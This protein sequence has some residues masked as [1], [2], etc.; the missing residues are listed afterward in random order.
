MNEPIID[1]AT[2]WPAWPTYGLTQDLLPTIEN[3]AGQGRRVAVATLVNIVGTSP[4]PLGSEMAISDRGEVAGY[5]SG[6][7]VEGAVAAE[8][9]A[10]MADGKPRLL[11]YGAGS[12]VLDVQLTCGG[13]IGIFVRVLEDATSYAA[14]LRSARDNRQLLE[15]HIN[16]DNGKH[17]YVLPEAQAP[18]A[19]P[20]ANAVFIKSF[21]PAPRL[22]AIGKNP[23]AMAVCQ[24]AEPLGYEVQLAVPYGPATPPPGARLSHYD[25][26]AL[27]TA[28]AE[29]ELDAWTAVYTLTHHPDDD[30][31]VLTWALPSPAFAVG[32]LGSRTKIRERL[33]RLSREGLDEAS[34]SR[35]LAPAGL[36]I[37]AQGPREIALAIFAQIISLQPR[38][39]CRLPANYPAFDIMESTFGTP[40]C[41]VPSQ[42]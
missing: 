28:L 33:Q 42:A 4:R 27:K 34:I 15:V 17:R 21:P 40:V 8:A 13:R 29:V 25:Q 18:S 11:D 14:T 3:W 38:A 31:D 37:G 35:L 32:V 36:D 24:L 39:A 2:N 12:P 26:R 30:V 7:C 9:L 10:A 16:L 23:V 20:A 41:A 19:N 1:L 6:G 22:I 5:V